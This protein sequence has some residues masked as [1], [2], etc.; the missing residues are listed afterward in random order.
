MGLGY[1][2]EE[3]QCVQSFYAGFWE[4]HSHAASSSCFYGLHGSFISGAV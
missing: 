1:L 4:P 2:W 3:Y